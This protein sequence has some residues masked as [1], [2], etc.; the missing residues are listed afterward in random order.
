MSTPEIQLKNAIENAWQKA[1]ATPIEPEKKEQVR[2]QKRSAT[3]VNCLAEEFN[4]RY[5]DSVGNFRTFWKGNCCNQEAFRK[6]E[7]LF[8]IVVARIQ[9]TPSQQHQ[10][11]PLDYISG[12]EWAIESE[13]NES[14][15]REVIIDMS[16]LVVADARDKL[17]VTSQRSNIRE[18]RLLEQC[19]PIAEACRGT[20]YFC[21]IAHPK[22][23]D[24]TPKPPRLHIL[25]P[26]SGWRLVQET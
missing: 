4:T 24:K 11:K 12:C 26:R 8:D 16:K 19:R 7:F 9:Q 18:E 25:S 13:L 22:Y 21:F 14:D 15:S 5:S 17:F 6:N 2:N 1:I 10:P 20:V 3:W 23:W